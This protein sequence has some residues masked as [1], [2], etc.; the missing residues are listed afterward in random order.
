MRLNP[1]LPL[2]TTRVPTI[3]L[4]SG[5]FGCCTPKTAP[6]LR[7]HLR[8]LLPS[9]VRLPPVIR[10]YP[11]AKRTYFSHVLSLY[12]FRRAL[13]CNCRCSG[14]QPFPG[15]ISSSD[16]PLSWLHRLDWRCRCLP[17][18]FHAPFHPFHRNH[19]LLCRQ[20]QAILTSF[21]TCQKMSEASRICCGRG[22]QSPSDREPD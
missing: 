3:M 14:P 7:H 13:R 9:Q 10:L 6:S 5:G 20:A 2:R 19:C 21:S 1:P 11:L 18:L 17:C 22:L 4:P 15:S 16:T 8:D 12:T